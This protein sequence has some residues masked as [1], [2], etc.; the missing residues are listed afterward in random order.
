MNG[1]EIEA[2]DWHRNGVAGSG[3]YVGI[4]KDPIEGRMLVIDFGSDDPEANDYETCVAVLNLDEAARGNIFMHA[5]PEVENS[6]G[7]AWR[8]DRL[9]AEYTPLM[10]AKQDE[11]WNRFH[12]IDNLETLTESTEC[13]QSPEDDS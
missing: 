13:F 9:G 7:N 3:F 8:G 10:R 5:R 4:V 6:G 2:V 11:Y 12:N 1:P